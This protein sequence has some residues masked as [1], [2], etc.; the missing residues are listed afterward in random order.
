MR[1]WTSTRDAVGKRVRLE[2]TCRAREAVVTFEHLCGTFDGLSLAA[3]SSSSAEEVVASAATDPRAARYLSVPLG[4]AGRGHRRASMGIPYA[5]RLG[6]GA[7][8]GAS[9]VRRARRECGACGGI[10]TA[11]SASG[12]T[13]GR[14]EKH[15]RRRALDDER[16]SRDASGVSRATISSGRT[17]RN[18]RGGARGRLALKENARRADETARRVGVENQRLQTKTNQQPHD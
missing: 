10:Q 18:S 7:R 11:P 6:N 5:A 3:E 1:R 16:A 2:R 4:C 9:S 15:R 13:G 8:D 14:G 17:A 12:A